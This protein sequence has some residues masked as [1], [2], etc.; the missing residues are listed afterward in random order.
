MQKALHGGADSPGTQEKGDR[1]QIR[2]AVS[3][4]Q[5]RPREARDCPRAH[6]EK[7]ERPRPRPAP[8]NQLWLCAGR[9]LGALARPT[10]EDASRA[11]EKESEMRMLCDLWALAVGRF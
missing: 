8:Q 9:R 10:G 3:R 11:S 5:G 7:R 6:A 2:S 4:W 1:G